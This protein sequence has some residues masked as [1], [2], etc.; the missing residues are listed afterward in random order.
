M[1]SL[2][3]LV[4]IPSLMGRLLGLRSLR[5]KRMED[6]NVSIPSLMGR[7]LGSILKDLKYG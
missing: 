6:K 7:L 2:L 5:R 1:W 3:S 4:S